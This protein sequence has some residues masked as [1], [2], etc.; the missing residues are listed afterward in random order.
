MEKKFFEKPAIFVGEL[1]INVINLHK[2]LAFYQAAIGFQVLEQTDRKAV[3]T[4]DGKTPLLTL[5]QPG[6]VVPKEE[7]TSGLY[8][9]AILLPT[10]ADLSAFLKHI[11]NS[12][13]RL[14]ASDHTV[15][16]ALYLS[17]PDGNGI[18]V[19][20]D[21]PSSEWTWSEGGE[22]AMATDPLDGDGLLAES[23][24]EWDGLPKDTVMGHIHLHVQ[25]LE[26]TNDFYTNGLG[27]TV[28]TK[29]PGALF[30]STGGYH[31]HIGLNVWNGIGART[32]AK[33]SVGL[34]WYSL[35]FPNE[36]TRKQ[37]I[38]RLEQMGVSVVKGQD[39]YS[40]ED[41]S[42]NGIQLRVN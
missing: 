23:N 19:Y 18:E 31:H 29:Y 15:S 2:S 39:Y 42:G 27:F 38:A 6:N 11:I 5:E 26:K 41:P 34:N 16:E 22:V 14:G 20:H 17:D 33:N 9:F 4:A 35:V 12:K 28:V 30:T 7:R 32:P 36:A 1:S 8:H 25:D 37:V 24:H 3:L 13:V 40:T 10:R 21:R